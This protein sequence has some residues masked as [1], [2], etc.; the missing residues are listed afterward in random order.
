MKK[1]RRNRL[2]SL[3]DFFNFPSFTKKKLAKLKKKF[4][5][6]TSNCTQLFLNS[7][8]DTAFE[9]KSKKRYADENLLD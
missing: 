8:A 4:K 6:K 3:D 1:G 5:E 2:H 7:C 9:K